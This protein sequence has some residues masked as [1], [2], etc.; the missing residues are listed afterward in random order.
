MIIMDRLTEL[1][2][3]FGTDKGTMD[4]GHGYT[5]TYTKL[6]EDL[7]NEPVKMMEI[8]VCDPRFPGA[9]LKMWEE[10]FP[11]LCLIGFDINPEARYFENEFTHI[12]IGN[13]GNPFDLHK[14]IDVYR[15]NYDIIIDDGSHVGEHVCNSF[16]VLF[17][18]VKPGGYY[19][20]EDLHSAF[21]HADVTLP[22]L[23]QII[24]TFGFRVVSMDFSH[25]GKLL[26][27][28]KEAS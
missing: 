28:K 21:T 20:I 25:G 15:G 14:C 12:F 23:L 2:N 7:V 5:E 6:F 22:A 13:Q 24:T 11:I 16:Q 27:M 26:V 19:I 10:Y 9:S 1:A 8:G 4:G 18:Y 3:K 17:P